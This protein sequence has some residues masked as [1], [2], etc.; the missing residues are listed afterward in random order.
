MRMGWFVLV[1]VTIFSSAAQASCPEGETYCTESPLPGGKAY[2][3]VENLNPYVQSEQ[4]GA[5]G[6]ISN[7][8]AGQGQKVYDGDGNY[9]GRLN[10][11]IY[12]PE[13]VQHYGQNTN[14]YASGYTG[15]GAASNPYTKKNFTVSP[16]R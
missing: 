15:D 11:N 7:P 2:N 4:S 1:A 8:Y 10:S 5:P 12:D 9:R 14:P 13:S 16:S 6:S 3:P